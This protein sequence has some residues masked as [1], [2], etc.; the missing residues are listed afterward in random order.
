M[1]KRVASVGVAT[2]LAWTP[3]GGDILFIETTAMPGSG[4]L[5]LTGQ[6]GDVMKESAHGGGLVPALALRAS[7][8]LPDDYFAKHDLHI[9]V[10]AGAVPKD[11]PSAGIAMATS[12][13]SLLTNHKVDS[14]PGDDGRDHAHRSSAADR[15][16][17]GEGARREARR[18]Q[19]R[20]CCPSATR[21][22][23]T[24]C[25]RKCATRWQFVSV[26]E[27]SEVFA[28]A[29]GKRIIT[30]VLLGNEEPAAPTTSSRCARTT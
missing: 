19:E 24:T 4:K 6:L 5:T 9:H 29:L 23:S 20:C 25:P 30:P 27:L 26:E 18:D 1:K 14:G 12:I 10:P 8:G 11:G 16:R 28:H 21:W 13:A 15:R 17:Q 3:V 22:I 7:S 2:G